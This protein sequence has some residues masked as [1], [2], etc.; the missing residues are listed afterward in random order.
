MLTTPKWLQGMVGPTFTLCLLAF[1]WG[2]LLA[3]PEEAERR[4]AAAA[5]F[6]LSLIIASWLT[7]DARKR[8]RNLPYDFDGLVFFFWPLI[9]PIYLLQTRKLRIF[10]TLLLFSALC[11][12][13]AAGAFLG[14]LLTDE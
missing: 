10:L 4:A 7:A 9:L 2:A 12:V 1:V 14:A 13:A 5:N 3:F 8:N 11:L 6:A